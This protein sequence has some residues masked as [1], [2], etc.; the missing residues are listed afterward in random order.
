VVIAPIV[1]AAILMGVLPN[2]FLRP[3]EPSAARVIQQ[4]RAQV[5]AQIQASA[6]PAPQTLLPVPGPQPLVPR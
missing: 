2:L 4:V 3:I 1:A 6:P 5:P